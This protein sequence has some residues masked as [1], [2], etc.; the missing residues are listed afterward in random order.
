MIQYNLQFE[1]SEEAHPNVRKAN[2]QVLVVRRL[3]IATHWINLYPVDNVVRSAI[4]YPTNNSLSGDFA[5][6]NPPDSDLSVE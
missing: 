6:T 5:I 2:V 1:K 4:T 3:D